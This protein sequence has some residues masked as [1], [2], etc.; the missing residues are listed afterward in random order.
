[1]PAGLQHLF[2]VWSA[3]FANYAPSFLHS[4]ALGYIASAAIGAAAIVLIAQTLRWAA[5]R[6]AG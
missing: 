5:L 6:R 3:P 1:V 2:A 4:Q